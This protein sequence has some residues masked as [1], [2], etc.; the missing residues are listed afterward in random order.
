MNGQSKNNQKNQIDKRMIFSKNE[1]KKKEKGE[2]YDQITVPQL[3]EKVDSGCQL[4]EGASD[5][6]PNLLFQQ[7]RIDNR[8]R[9][10][11]VD[12]HQGH[13]RTDATGHNA[14]IAFQVEALLI[15]DHGVAA[16][17]DGLQ[18]DLALHLEI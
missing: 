7:G 10:G 11:F 9:H 5:T 4:Y 1:R 18:T 13:G 12:F 15:A 6:G 2:S 3:A 17:V 14:H 8:L 16:Q